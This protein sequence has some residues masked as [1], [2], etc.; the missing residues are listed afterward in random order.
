MIVNQVAISVRDRQRSIDWYGRTL[1]YLP[2]GEQVFHAPMPEGSPDV[3]AL[4]G[5]P[6]AEFAMSWAVDQQQFFQLEFFQYRHPEVQP[7]PAD[8]RLCDIGYGMVGV[9]VADFDGAVARLALAGAPTLTEPLGPRGDRRVCVRDPD[10]VLLELLERDVP[11]A[12]APPRPR[13]EIGVATRSITVSVPDLERSCDLFVGALGMQPVHDVALHGAEHEALW[14]LHGASRRCV[15]L[16]SGDFWVEL[17]QYT[18]P[19]GRPWP[20]GYS[21]CDQGILN[22]ALGARSLNDY[23]ATR[24][25]VI[26]AGFRTNLEVQLPLVACTYLMD[27]QGFSAEL[28]YVDETLDEALGFVP[29]RP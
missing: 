8:W 24:D 1:G 12:S 25:R 19:V 28:L 18:D 14:G 17:V 6:G 7:L 15:L 23:K 2:A 16:S 5:I 22:I 20:D 13:P 3:A 27:H 9:Y 10:G 26:A 11:L 29:V 4:Q 21:I